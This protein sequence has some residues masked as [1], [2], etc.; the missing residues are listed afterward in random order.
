MQITRTNERI[1]ELGNS[2]CAY[3]LGLGIINHDA[4]KIFRV[5]D[6]FY[7]INLGGSFLLEFLDFIIQKCNLGIVLIAF[8]LS[9]SIH[10]KLAINP[11]RNII[12]N[13]CLGT[14]E[15]TR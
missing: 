3:F 8:F 1:T 10:R 7:S 9:F 5:D 14:F 6:L 12:V 2:P 13:Q 15:N 11:S 4:I